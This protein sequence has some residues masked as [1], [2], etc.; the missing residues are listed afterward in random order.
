MRKL[1]VDSAGELAIVNS[2]LKHNEKSRVWLMRGELRG[3]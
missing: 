3:R 2:T 1:A